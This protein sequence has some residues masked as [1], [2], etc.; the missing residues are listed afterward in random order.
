MEARQF[1]R[2]YSQVIKASSLWFLVRL[3]LIAYAIPVIYISAVLYDEQRMHDWDA[4]A[5]IGALIY[6][7]ILSAIRLWDYCNFPRW[8]RSQSNQSANGSGQAGFRF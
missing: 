5:L 2:R 8:R 1:L 6:S 7:T 3:S 4:E